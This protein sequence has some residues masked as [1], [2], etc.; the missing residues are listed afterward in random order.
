M[1]RVN[2]YRAC[3]WCGP[4]PVRAIGISFGGLTGNGSQAT[5]P[6]HGGTCLTPWRR[7]GDLRKGAPWG[8]VS[9][10]D[11][12]PIHRAAGG[13]TCKAHHVSYGVWLTGLWDAPG[14]SHTPPWV[15]HT[16]PWGHIPAHA[17]PWSLTMEPHNVSR[18]SPNTG[19]KSRR[20]R[21][22]VYHATLTLR[23]AH[24][25]REFLHLTVKWLT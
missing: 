10:S 9:T 18:R 24:K 13:P 8:S 21:W 16:P 20:G 15:H 25:Y 3:V 2:E 6:T 14:G 22:M 12:R 17:L 11:R 1:I 23:K 5:H 4:L 19:A 7:P